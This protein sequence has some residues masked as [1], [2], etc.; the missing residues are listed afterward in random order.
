MREPIVSRVLVIFLY[1]IFA[2]GI[3]GTI[4]LPFLLD[5]Y[6]G[7]FRAGHY[8]EAAYRAF[9]IPFMICV[10][11]PGLWIILEMI[12]MLRS[13]AQGPFIIRNVRALSRIGVMLLVISA[14]FSAKCFVHFSFLT[15]AC[16]FLFLVCGFFAF[17]MSNLF[18]QAVIYKEEND[19]TI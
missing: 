9:I 7:L 14:M 17:T 19:L 1:I 3:F 5:L 8:L 11:I 13:I 2:L 10:A 15:M 18:R 12:W 6:I 4:T 16:A